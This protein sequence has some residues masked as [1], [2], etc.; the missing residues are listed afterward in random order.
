MGLRTIQTGLLLLLLAP[1]A[2]PAVARAQEPVIGF[3]PWIGYLASP[4][5]ESDGTPATASGV[6][7]ASMGGGVAIGARFDATLPLP[8]L[9][10]RV[11]LG[12]SFSS[13]GFE[14]WDGVTGQ[15]SYGNPA[16]KDGSAIVLVTGGITLSSGSDAPGPS[17]VLAGGVKILSVPGKLGEALSDD[18][19]GPTAQI[20]ASF[21]LGT[22]ARLDISDFVSRASLAF[23][24]PRLE[25]LTTPQ[26]WQH[27]IVISIGYQFGTR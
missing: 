24:Y 20:G 2:T 10:L 17:L 14:N 4:G 25:S 1:W 5:T 6:V 26:R 16:A 22:R 13:V 9:G 15:T 3:T 23:S 8:L 27:S 7:H 12:R 19:T 11:T 18:R 21:P